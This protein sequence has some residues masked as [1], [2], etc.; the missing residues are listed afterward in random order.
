MLDNPNI[1]QKKIADW[2]FSLLKKTFEN[3]K[4]ICILLDLEISSNL[5]ALEFLERVTAGFPIVGL[6]N[7]EDCEYAYS[8]IEDFDPEYEKY[9]K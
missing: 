1:E 5:R 6:L 8:S 2:Y 3:K 7:N 9:S 4:T